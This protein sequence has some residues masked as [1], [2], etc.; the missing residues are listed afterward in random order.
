VIEENF[1]AAKLILGDCGSVFYGR[2]YDALVTD[3]PYGIGIAAN[4]VRQ[5]H[6]KKDWDNAPC[7]DEL[8]GYLRKLANWHII[9][10][11]NY[12][13]LPPSQNFLIW[14]KVQPEGL[15]LSMCEY[16]WTNMSKPAKL[17]RRHVVSYDKT[18]PTQKPLELM[19][20]C[21]NQLPAAE[22][23]YIFDPF[24]GS[25]TTGVAALKLG[26]KFLGIEI[27]RE[28]FDMACRRIEATVNEIES[29]KD[30]IEGLGLFA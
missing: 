24:M 19:T 8:L 3:P 12:F 7:S 21:L 16:A 14:D 26:K 1:G 28:Y 17:F 20:W 23:D 2:T 9:W 29:G 15:T 10:G 30:L 18:H 25:G 6:D 13:N 5:R 11:G 27:D 22:S 4:P